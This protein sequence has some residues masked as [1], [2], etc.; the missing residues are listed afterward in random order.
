M[1]VLLVC[2]SAWACKDKNPANEDQ[3]LVNDL[4]A[5][6]Q[7][8]YQSGDSAT[9]VTSNVSLP[10]SGNISTLDG[11]VA[12]EIVWTSNNAAISVSG[13]VT[14]PQDTD[15]TVTLIA[16]ANFKGY[17]AA[18]NFELTVIHQG[19]VIPP[20]VHTYRFEYTGSVTTNFTSG[21]NASQVNLDETLFNVTGT[22]V[23]NVGYDPQAIGLNKDGSTRLY[24]DKVNGEGNILS[25]SVNEGEINSIV[26]ALGANNTS[27]LTYKVNGLSQILNGSSTE[28]NAIISNFEIHENSFTIQ[29]ANITSS[30]LFI[31]YID[32]EVSGGSVTPPP[33]N[34]YVLTLVYNN[35]N[36]NGSVYS[37]NLGVVASVANPTWAGH[38]FLGWYNNELLT[39][40]AVNFP[41]TIT[42]NSTIY[43]K[44]EATGSENSSY[45]LDYPTGAATTTMGAG[46]NAATLG[47]NPSQFSVTAINGGQGAPGLNA[48]GSIRLYAAKATGNGN[49][50][51]ITSNIGNIT[52]IEAKLGAKSATP[53]SY[54]VNGVAQS[55]AFSSA[56]AS[57]Q[58]IAYTINAA[59]VTLKNTDMN[60]N[61]N[62][63][64]IWQIK[65]YVA[66]GTITPPPANEAPKEVIEYPTW[67]LFLWDL[68]Q[69]LGISISLPEPPIFFDSQSYDYGAIDSRDA[70][71]YGFDLYT[72][73]PASQELVDDYLELLLWAGFIDYDGLG[74]YESPNGQFE[75][76][77]EYDVMYAGVV[78]FEIGVL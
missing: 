29:N 17:P 2:L 37:S 77:V 35:G 45:V 74:Y 48:N 20:Q 62:Q 63:L 39:G 44:W 53:L 52:S 14:R 15:V 13:V 73:T 33:T 59:T 61:S 71:F 32:I 76:Y 21:N 36:P 25:V 47:L 30:Q 58:I 19:A 23:P 69:Y 54:T 10:S 72:T 57:A 3:Q 56:E 22:E 42:S 9:S 70:G 49:S 4:I 24:Y 66:G 34:A 50:L 51:V 60:D 43:A 64:F 38:N 28:A 75:I 27:A 41:Y 12:V 31:W 1:V 11:I 55:Q 6:I 40:S 65:I 8:G 67:N 16:S 18:K 78:Y 26:I 68:S 5:S 7:V 46:N